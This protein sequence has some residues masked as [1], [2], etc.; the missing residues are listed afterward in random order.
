MNPSRHWTLAALLLITG[1]TVLAAAQWPVFPYF[2]DSYYHLSV[3]RGFQEAGGPVLQDFWEAAPAGHPHLYPPLFHLL[4]LPGAFLGIPPIWMA[5]LWSWLAL[6]LLLTVTW[7][8]LK[9]AAS[10]RIA[11]LAV[12]VLATPFSFYLAS[13]NY[14]PATLTLAASLGILLA[15]KKKRWL[16]GGLLLGLSFWLHAGLPWLL[17]L[18]LFFFSLFEP[19][20]RKTAWAAI[21]IGLL[22][23]SPWILH[24]ARHFNVIHIQ[25]RPEDAY[26]DIFPLFLALACAG[27]LPA[28]RRQTPMGR[29]FVALAVGF[30]PMAI[31]YRFRY[32]SA[33][34][35][36]TWLLLAA[37]ALDRLAEKIRPA[38][39]AG[40]LLGLLLVA[41]PSLRSS[42]AG[43][44][45]A[46]G[47]TTFRVLAGGDTAQ[48]IY[49]EPL[50]HEKFIPELAD[51]L[52]SHCA[53]D[54]LFFCNTPYVGGML[55]AFTGRAMTN[56]MLTEMDEKE[57]SE[58]AGAAR[59]IVWLKNPSGGLSQ[60][61]KL[62]FILSRVPLEPVAETELAYFFRNS[63][64]TGKKQ[65]PSPVIP[66]WAA[67]GLI[68]LTAG[69]VVYDLKRV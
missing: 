58:Q 66:W 29:Y 30:L 9:T 25:P 38:W 61:K 20:F 62:R 6:P 40:A 59:I 48:R 56:Q 53:E 65:V 64:S 33:Q 4:W 51:T 22:I 67:Y 10:T 24:V 21:G 8:T 47:D 54:E 28:W 35:S 57:V 17:L 36:F 41:A 11:C 39:L 19:E 2:L 46:W 15:L 16:A 14:L 45:Y 27:L 60:E 12:A 69:T 50:Y 34:G 1:I 5:K 26:V 44:H 31:S 37:V 3:I 23:A 13:V 42:T 52:K 49:S 68:I 7:T 18:G 32:F 55:H 63:G 43:L